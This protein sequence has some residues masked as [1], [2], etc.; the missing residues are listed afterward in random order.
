MRKRCICWVCV[1]TGGGGE[2]C[3][4]F[5][6]SKPQGICCCFAIANSCCQ[7]IRN[8]NASLNATP[9]GVDSSC[10]KLAKCSP[11]QT[12]KAFSSRIDYSIPSSAHPFG[13]P[14]RVGMGQTSLVLVCYTL[15]SQAQHGR[16]Y[17]GTTVLL[18]GLWGSTG[19][20]FVPHTFKQP[21][22]TAA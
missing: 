19:L 8:R 13:V 22:K 16:L 2:T 18:L 9:V 11:S 3:L 6:K 7:D 15:S 17:W 5:S 10:I 20:H 4:C 1:K 14:G 21:R 12:T